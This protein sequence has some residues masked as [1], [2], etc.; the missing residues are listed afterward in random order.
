MRC[1]KHRGVGFSYCNLC[2]VEMLR[3][4]L[5][6]LTGVIENIARANDRAARQQTFSAQCALG[7]AIAEA[8]MLVKS[9]P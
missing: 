2:E 5:E 1:E 8:E 4:E 6:A 7:Q 9:I 3:E